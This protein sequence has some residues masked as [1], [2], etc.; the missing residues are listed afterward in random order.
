[1]NHIFLLGYRNANLGKGRAF[2]SREKSN[3]QTVKLV[4]SS[5]SGTSQLEEVSLTVTANRELFMISAHG[6]H[7]IHRV[8]TG[9]TLDSEM[10][11]DDISHS[12][13]VELQ[14]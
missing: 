2:C 8:L 4:V 12:L 1:M 5:P 13:S 6:Q 10:S 14:I 3:D 7:I 11:G 9:P